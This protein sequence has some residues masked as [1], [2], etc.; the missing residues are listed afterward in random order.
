[1]QNYFQK[2]TYIT[3]L[4]KNDLQTSVKRLRKSL[5]REQIQDCIFKQDYILL[6]DYIFM[7]DF[8]WMQDYNF[9][10]DFL[11]MQDS[12]AK[13]AYFIGWQI[14]EMFGKDD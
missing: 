9:M 12:I 5:D 1:M 14:R 7:Q 11:W 2:L 4:D 10:Q 8:S 13:V 6:Q 3:G